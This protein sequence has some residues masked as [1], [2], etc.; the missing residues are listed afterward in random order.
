[1]NNKSGVHVTYI[2]MGKAFDT[3]SH[4]K[5]LHK[6]RCLGI[7]GQLIVWIENFLCELLQYMKVNFKLS[8]P[9]RVVSRVPL[10]KV[11]GPLFYYLY[12]QPHYCFPTLA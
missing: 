6:L 5:F 8:N 4:M 2:D 3:V 9:A 1:M 11:L 10:R 12:K 7:G